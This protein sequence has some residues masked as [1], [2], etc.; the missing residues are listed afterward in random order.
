MNEPRIIELLSK[1]GLSLNTMRQFSLGWN[2]NELF[3]RRENWGL[4]KEMKE[5]GHPRRQWLPKCIVIPSW[6]NDKPTKLKIRR[7]DWFEEDK[8]PKYVEVS[9]SKQTPSVYGDQS[10][11]VL[12][13]ES[14]LDAMLIQQEAA[15]LVCCMAL[16][17][18]SK[19][20]DI[21]THEWL[22]K[23]SIILLSLDFDEAGKKSILFG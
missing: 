3:D 20:P 19:K 22:K 18:V 5:N 14:E 9:G 1:R 17:G 6:S 11:P 2:P 13:V 15:H 12:I 8:F 4:L 7:D 16:G 23:A 10:K 21:E